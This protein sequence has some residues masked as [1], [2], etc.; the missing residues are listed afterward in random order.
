MKPLIAQLQFCSW[1]TKVGHHEPMANT[2]GSLDIATCLEREPG[3]FFEPPY[4]EPYESLCVSD[5]QQA[6]RLKPQVSK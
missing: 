5:H 3:R 6:N 1:A 2:L 4:T